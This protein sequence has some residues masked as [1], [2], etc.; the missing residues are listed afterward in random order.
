MSQQAV[1]EHYGDEAALAMDLAAALN[2]EIHDLVA[3]GADVIQID[4]PYMQA[5]LEQARRFAIPAI[6][7]SLEGVSATTVL[8]TCFGYGALVGQK[9]DEQYRAYP[10]LEELTASVVDQLSI[11]AAQPNLDLSILGRLGDKTVVLGVIDLGDDEVESVE[12]VAGRIRAALRHIP[13]E[14]LALSPDCGMKYLS[15]TAACGKLAAMAEAARVVRAEIGAA[16]GAP[17]GE[18]PR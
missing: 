7:R 8:H 12:T 2:E 13:A 18:Q 10:F 5:R 16:D 1:D 15:R 6:N 4:E 3:A 9:G 17:G 14:R 11:E